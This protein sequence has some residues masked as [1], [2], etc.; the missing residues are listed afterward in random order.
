LTGDNNDNMLFGAGGGDTLN[1]G[2]GNDT[3]FAFDTATAGTFEILN[4]GFGA[5][6][7]DY[8][9]A[10]AAVT[11]V[12]GLAASDGTNGFATFGSTTDIYNSI[13]N[14]SGSSFADSLTG[15]HANNVINGRGGDDIMSGGGRWG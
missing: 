11:A 4:G 3:L 13:E 14:L 8:R 5:D 12:L 15:N 9:F 2:G 1:G 7:A 6:T 10:D